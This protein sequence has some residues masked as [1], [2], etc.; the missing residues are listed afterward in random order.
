MEEILNQIT[1]ENF[2]IVLVV[3]LLFRFEN[4]LKRLEKSIDE[5]LLRCKYCEAEKK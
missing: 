2:S 1:P 3:Y 5:L 4:T